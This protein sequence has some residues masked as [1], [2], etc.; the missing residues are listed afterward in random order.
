LQVAS[1]GRLSDGEMSKI[2]NGVKLADVT[3]DA[4]WFNVAAALKATS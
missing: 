4:T 1:E 2:A 3:D